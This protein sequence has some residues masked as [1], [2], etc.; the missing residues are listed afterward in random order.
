L[1]AQL[2]LP[3]DD[4]TSTITITASQIADIITT[5]DTEHPWKKKAVYTL[6]ETAFFLSAAYFSVR[7]EA[8]PRNI[9]NPGGFIYDARKMM[10]FAVG[11]PCSSG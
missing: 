2:R 4:T 5:M 11:L 6:P 9:N 7:P 10:Y 3:S 8:A 1:A